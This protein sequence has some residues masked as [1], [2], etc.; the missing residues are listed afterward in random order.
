M[1]VSHERSVTPVQV[2]TRVSAESQRVL[3]VE[4]QASTRG[5]LQFGLVRAGFQV[6][7]VR[8]AEEAESVLEQGPSP[9]LW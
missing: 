3:V 1:A 7:S 5:L 8:S 4:P 6:S 2:P 9:A